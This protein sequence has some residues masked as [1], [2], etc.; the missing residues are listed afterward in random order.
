MK[1]IFLSDAHLTRRRDDYYRDLMRFLDGLT[2]ENID[3][4]FIAGDF[5]DFW[6]C[7]DNHIYPYF[8][9]AIGKLLMLQAS[10][11]QI[12]YCEGNHDFFLESYFGRKLGMT[13]YADWAVL[14]IDGQ[15][16][17]VAHGDLV[18]RKNI[19]YQ[20]F[21]KI[22]RSKLFY[23]VQKR[24]P[25]RILWILARLGSHTSRGL[26][27]ESEEQLVQE[28]LGFSMEKFREGFDTVI[29]GHSHQPTLEEFLIAGR[30][31]TFAILGDWTRHKSYLRYEDGHYRLC[32]YQ[33]PA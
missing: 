4:L 7:K 33:A 17:L 11:A 23:E 32:Y 31:K 21:R 9:E 19:K 30:R 24:T 1:C 10:G 3:R 5:F 13:V 12:I 18:D 2:V 22:L 28:M 14:D 25:S 16:T 8:E 20:I 27:S 29:L 6:F 26:P 15:K